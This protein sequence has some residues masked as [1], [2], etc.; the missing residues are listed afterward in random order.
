MT[1]DKIWS[2]DYVPQGMDGRKGELFGSVSYTDNLGFP[3]MRLC[4]II[5]STLEL[6]WHIVQRTHVL[7][8]YFYP[9]EPSSCVA[10]QHVYVFL[11]TNSVIFTSTIPHKIDIDHI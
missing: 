5:G 11:Y 4:C 7:S 3:V 9:F 2:N 10:H 6:Y 1:V 8:C